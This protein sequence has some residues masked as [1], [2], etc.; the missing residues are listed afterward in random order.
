[1]GAFELPNKTCC[2]ADACTHAPDNVHHIERPED[3]LSAGE[4]RFLADEEAA[5]RGPHCGTC[6]CGRVIAY[7]H[8][9]VD[10]AVHMLHPSS[11]EIVLTGGAP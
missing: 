4:L 3:Y 6:R 8:T 2:D 11:I 1:M 7:R 10:G 5:E 9:T